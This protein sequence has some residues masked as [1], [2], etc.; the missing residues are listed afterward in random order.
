MELYQK[1]QSPITAEIEKLG[2]KIEDVPFMRALSPLEES[3]YQEAIE[4]RKQKTHTI[5]VFHGIDKKY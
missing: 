3:Y 5:D 4:G 2:K 1:I